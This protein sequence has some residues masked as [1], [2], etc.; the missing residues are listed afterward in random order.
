[1]VPI[2]LAVIFFFPCQAIQCWTGNSWNLFHHDYHDPL[3]YDVKNCNNTQWCYK[4]VD[5]NIYVC[6]DF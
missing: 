5:Y 4:W 2:I 3:Q 6:L 1:M